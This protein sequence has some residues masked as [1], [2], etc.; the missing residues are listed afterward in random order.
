MYHQDNRVL[1]EDVLRF[2]ENG[3]TNISSSSLLSCLSSFSSS[4]YDLLFP[5]RIRRISPLLSVLLNCLFLLSLW[6]SRHYIMLNLCLL[7]P[8]TGAQAATSA[9]PVAQ[10]APAASPVST[11]STREDR[12]EPIR[13]LRRTMVKTMTAALR[14]PHFNY[15]D[16]VCANGVDRLGENN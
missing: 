6:S 13:G 8:L 9:E 16:E 10:E 4:P 7:K 12:V 14:V 1:K 15:S 11:A 5:R 3:G 2:L